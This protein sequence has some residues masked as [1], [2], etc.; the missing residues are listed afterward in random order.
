[1]DPHFYVFYTGRRYTNRGHVSSTI[2]GLWSDICILCSLHD[3]TG[4]STFIARAAFIL[5]FRNG[6]AG[7]RKLPGGPHVAHTIFVGK[8]FER[9]RSLGAMLI[10]TYFLTGQVGLRR[11]VSRVFLPAVA[12]TVQPVLR[13]VRVLSKRY[14]YRAN[15]PHVCLRRKLPRLVSLAFS[16]FVIHDL[17]SKF[18]R[19]GI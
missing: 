10:V 3:G 2:A 18:S 11:S 5:L 17:A 9:N 4:H 8:Y 6:C 15:Q 13:S 12:R 14:L 1:M 16:L 7:H 19:G